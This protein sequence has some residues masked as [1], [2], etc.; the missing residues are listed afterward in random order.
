MG[1]SIEDIYMARSLADQNVIPLDSFVVD[2]GAQEFIGGIDIYKLVEVLSEFL[3]RTEV[4]TLPLASIARTRFSGSIFKL[5]GFQYLAL[6][7]YDSE[8]SQKFDLNHDDVPDHLIGRANLVQNFGTTEHVLNQAN[9]FKVI[10][11]LTSADGGLMWH[12][13]PMSDYYGH[14]FFKY[15][16][17]LFVQLAKANHYH[18]ASLTCSQ[19]ASTK[20][21]DQ[22]FFDAGMLEIDSKIT[23]IQCM[24]TRT[25]DAPFQ[26]PLDYD[27]TKK[28]DATA[29]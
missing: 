5:Q 18:F 1:T 21:I 11:D 12:S 26:C 19:S 25:D 20:E 2:L 13:V 6:D 27:G 15:D 3:P 29:A 4:E 9:C 8:I 16:L 28:I 10:H 24:L 14:G 22:Q 17:K 23:T 7:V